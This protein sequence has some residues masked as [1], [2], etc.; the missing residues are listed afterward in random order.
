MNDFILFLSDISITRDNLVLGAILLAVAL[1]VFTLGFILSGVKSN[2]ERRVDGLIDSEDRKENSRVRNTLESL[3]PFYIPGDSKE[4]DNIRSQLMHAGYHDKKAIA[5]FYAIKLFSFVVGV[6]FSALIFLLF[7]DA[8]WRNFFMIGAVFFGLFIPNVILKKLIKTRQR[9][10]RG[11]IPDVLDLLVVCTE[12]GLGFLAALR[13]VANEAYISHPELADELDTVCAKVKAGVE[14]PQAFSELVV[15]TGLEEL[16]GLV[17]MLSH[18]SRIGGSLATTLRDYTEDYRDKRNQQAEEMAAKMPT[19]M[20]FPMLL[21]I[22]PCFF[23]VAVGP[24]IL[25]LK[26]AF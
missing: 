15:R 14:L 19:K 16:N 8:S 5:N 26:E 4:R 7:A 23:I 21:F 3:A 9:K 22:W 11:G 6:I 12:S 10:I 25:I 13:R 18:A 17:S 24:A 2:V 20:M 1:F